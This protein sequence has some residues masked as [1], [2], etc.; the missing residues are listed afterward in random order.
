VSGE[1]KNKR[2]ELIPMST[3]RH[4]SPDEERRREVH[5]AGVFKD[6]QDIAHISGTHVVH[7]D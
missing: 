3:R 1:N 7:F 4:P 6:A 5:V 2:K